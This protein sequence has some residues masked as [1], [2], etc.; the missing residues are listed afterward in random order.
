MER[1]L[2]S[3]TRSS[4]QSS[5]RSS[6]ATT[7]SGQRDAPQGGDLCR[8]LGIEAGVNCALFLNKGGLLYN[9]FCNK[10]SLKIFSAKILVKRSIIL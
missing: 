2:A 6:W 10:L 3:S 9:S 4:T 8:G 7:S 5:R 1:S